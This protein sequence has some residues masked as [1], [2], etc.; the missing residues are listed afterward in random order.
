MK[1]QR[2][3]KESK[4]PRPEGKH[5]GTVVEPFPDECAYIRS[6]VKFHGA[7][8]YFSPD[9]R[10]FVLRGCYDCDGFNYECEN[11]LPVSMLYKYINSEVE[12][13]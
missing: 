4:R 6:N 7:P 5:L 2:E 12:Y 9:L 1:K 10:R 11:Y 3:I 8:W 13:S